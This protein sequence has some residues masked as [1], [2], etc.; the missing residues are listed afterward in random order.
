MGSFLSGARVASEISKA[1]EKTIK[2]HFLTE[3]LSGE[4]KNLSPEPKRSKRALYQKVAMKKLRP[5]YNPLFV[6]QGIESL[7]QLTFRNVFVFH[8]LTRVKKN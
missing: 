7:S 8:F 2:I 6:R 5:L 3:Q 4:P 1:V